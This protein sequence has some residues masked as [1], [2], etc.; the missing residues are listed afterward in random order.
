MTGSAKSH[1]YLVSKKEWA[2]CCWS[3]PI[4]VTICPIWDYYL[5]PQF[6]ILG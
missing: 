5:H 6:W 1:F 2:W 3:L 4:Y